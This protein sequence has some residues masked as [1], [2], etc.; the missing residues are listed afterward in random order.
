MTIDRPGIIRGGLVHTRAE[1]K[2]MEQQEIPQGLGMA[3]ARYPDAMQRFGAMSEAERQ[4]VIDSAHAVQSKQ[5]M[6]ALVERL[7]T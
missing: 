3:L 6:Q 2:R 7:M 5:E 1:V 4:P